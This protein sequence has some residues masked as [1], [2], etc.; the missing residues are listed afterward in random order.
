[1]SEVNEKSVVSADNYNQIKE[2]L[3]SNDEGSV[4]VAITILEQSDYDK[5]EV[6][7]M[8]I[9]KDCFRET[10]GSA[11]K[12][13]ELAPELSEKVAERL[14]KEDLDITK[15]SFK[16]IYELAVSRNIPAEIEFTLTILR[17]ELVELLKEFG[18]DFV[19]LIKA[20][21]YK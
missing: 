2:M 10:F 6:F 21:V 7:L 5:S 12:F 8:C 3:T 17:D 18:Y 20:K 9:L 4:T 14:K 16:E 19:N 1:M 11:S 13:K 15:L